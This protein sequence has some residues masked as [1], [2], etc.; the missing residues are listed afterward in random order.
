MQA[1]GRLQ[2]P[3]TECSAHAL[4]HVLKAY[5]IWHHWQREGRRYSIEQLELHTARPAVLAHYLGWGPLGLECAAMPRK[6]TLFC[7]MLQRMQK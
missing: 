5:S 3:D 4:L 6:P 7:G 1:Q 2:P